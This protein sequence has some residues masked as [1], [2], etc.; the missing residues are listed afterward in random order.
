MLFYARKG[1]GQ[2]ARDALKCFF[3][4]GID[5][6]TDRYDPNASVDVETQAILRL[7]QQ[8]TQDMKDSKARTFPTSVYRAG[9]YFGRRYSAFTRL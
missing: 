1:K 3:F 6:V 2:A 5:L 9:R 8:V 4:P 7:D